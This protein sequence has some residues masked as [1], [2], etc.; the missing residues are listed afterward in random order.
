M[1]DTK[2][3]A[4]SPNRAVA[5]AAFLLLLLY[6]TASV[7][8]APVSGFGN[9][10]GHYSL[11]LEDSEEVVSDVA[12]DSQGRILL[13]FQIETVGGDWFPAVLRLLPDGSNDPSGAMSGALAPTAP[14][15]KKRGRRRPQAA[16]RRRNLRQ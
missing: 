11:T 2:T 5:L 15:F 10:P 12:I 6:S 8:Q 13:A 7:A 14:V 1:N 16:K 3:S 4:P 9:R